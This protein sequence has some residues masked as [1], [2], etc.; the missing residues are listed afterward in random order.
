MSARP[1]IDWDE[2]LKAVDELLRPEIMFEGSCDFL[3][4]WELLTAH[5]QDQAVREN[6]AR[7]PIQGVVACACMALELALK[8]LITLERSTPQWT[9][10]FADLFKQVS[11][12]AQQE[13]A[14]IVLQDGKPT[15][16]EGVTDA[17]KLC[18]GTFEKWRYK[19]EHRNLDFYEGFIIAVTRAAHES[20]LRR[21]PE[22][23]NPPA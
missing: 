11:T 19:H 8:A 20:I 5:R 6:K 14:S 18:E 2:E 22:W 13:I 23:R 4:G 15:T 12:K 10:E 17:L 3:L 16:V 7:F 9:H 1:V 21:L